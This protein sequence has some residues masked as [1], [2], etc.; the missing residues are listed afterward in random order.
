[1]P[2]NFME[3]IFYDSGLKETIQDWRRRVEDC[4]RAGHHIGEQDEIGP[5]GGRYSTKSSYQCMHCM[6]IY[7][8]YSKDKRK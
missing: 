4:K 6:V 5:V 1:M 8:D 7:E 2:D 3:E